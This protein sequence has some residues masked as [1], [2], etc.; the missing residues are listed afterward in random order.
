MTLNDVR[1]RG[2]LLLGCINTTSRLGRLCKLNHQ[3][4][5][6]GNSSILVSLFRIYLKLVVIMFTVLA[7]L[8]KLLSKVG[9]NSKRQQRLAQRK[10]SLQA[11]DLQASAQQDV[12]EVKRRGEPSAQHLCKLSHLQRGDLTSTIN[13]KSMSGYLPRSRTISATS[14]AASVHFLNSS[15]AQTPA[16]LI[17]GEPMNEHVLNASSFISHAFAS[18]IHDD[19][20]CVLQPSAGLGN[21]SI[22]DL[23]TISETDRGVRIYALN[24]QE[25]AS[26]TLALADAALSL[27][28]APECASKKKKKNSSAEK[29]VSLLA[30]PFK[31]HVVGKEALQ[32]PPQD[33]AHSSQSSLVAHHPATQP[34]K[35]SRP[36]LQ[37]PPSRSHSHLVAF[38]QSRLRRK[39]SVV[40]FDP[41]SAGRFRILRVLSVQASLGVTKP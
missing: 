38:V 25:I 8:F 40:A 32:K 1:D 24:Q 22:S 2:G 37:D 12:V 31:S 19:A 5:S 17:I 30:K 18:I 20:C 14:I 21:P 4:Q 9:R 10:L 27:S 11:I 29:L 15:A 28:A 35:N 39:V 6:S 41:G 23:S 7:K 26:S 33:A 13:D 36:A 34:S 3:Q 16:H